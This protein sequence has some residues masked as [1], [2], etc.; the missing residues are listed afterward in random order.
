MTT[1]EELE[2]ARQANQ[3]LRE[4]LKQALI[5]IGRSQQ[6]VQALE[7]LIDLLQERLKTLE[8]QQA[9]D[10]H[11]SSL[12]PSSDR[13]VRPLMKGGVYSALPTGC[14]TRCKQASNKTVEVLPWDMVDNSTS[15]LQTHLRP[16]FGD[17]AF[18]TDRLIL[19]GG[20]IRALL[21]VSSP[22]ALRHDTAPTSGFHASQAGTDGK[23]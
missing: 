1:D 19:E 4:G 11:N 7:G 22:I 17:E 14:V 18:Q 9:K 6:R 2:Q 21:W 13:F 15:P 16:V 8:R 12:P 5:A 3:D 10:S 23:G 20:S